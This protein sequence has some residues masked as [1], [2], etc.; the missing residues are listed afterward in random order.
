MH[1]KIKFYNE[2]PK[3]ESNNQYIE[4]I[5]FQ[6]NGG[7]ISNYGRRLQIALTACQWQP[8]QMKKYSVAMVRKIFQKKKRKLNT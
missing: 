8:S 6:A 5:F 7:I 3:R 2:I 1:D 4:N